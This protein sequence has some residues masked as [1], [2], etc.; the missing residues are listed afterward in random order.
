[1]A[2]R[3]D[4]FLEHRW[5]STLVWVVCFAGTVWFFII[6]PKAFLPP[7]DSSVV[8]GVF[9]A[10]EGSSPEQMAGIQERVDEVLLKNPNVMA[11]IEV[12]GLS[13]F[14]ASNQGI[15][16]TF[17]KPPGDRPP[18]Q[19]E[20]GKMMGNIASIPGVMAFLRPFPVLEISTGATNQNQG[21][22]A[23]SVSGVNPQ[24][25]YD[26]SD[27]APGQVAHVS[28]ISH[29]AVGLLQQHAESRHRHP[30]RAGQDQRRLRSAHIGAFAQRLLAELSLP[31]QETGGSISGDSG[32]AGSARAKPPTICLCFTSNRTTASVS[33]R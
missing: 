13:Q 12:T 25:V 24:Q 28:G 11:T 18:I 19:E 23:F 20:A 14:I 6:V 26:A 31:H 7:G 30:A 33:C 1:M 22:Y 29:G 9:I 15:M 3:S 32:G 16:F 8:T 4:W 10:R 5:I 2:N 27:E 21:Q 17:L